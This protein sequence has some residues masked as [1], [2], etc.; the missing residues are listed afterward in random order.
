VLIAAVSAAITLALGTMLATFA[1]T[2]AQAPGSAAT[3]APGAAVAPPVGMALPAALADIPSD[4][5][6]LYQQA[7]QTCPGLS[8]AVLAGIGK[9]ES[10]NGLSALPGVSPGTVNSAGAGGP[11]QF[12][13]PTFASVIAKHVIPPGG[14]NPPSLYNA[15]DA[16]Y[17]AAYYLCDNGAH[18]GTNINGALWTYNHSQAYIN[19]VLAQANRYY[20]AAV[21]AQTPTRAA[22]A[23][24]APQQNQTGA[25]SGSSAT[26]RAV[27]GF[28]QAQIGSNYV[29]GGNGSADGGFDCSG[30][31][32]AAYRA[33]GIT[34]PRTAQTQYNTGPRLP[35]GAT[36]KPG[37]LVFFGTG[38]NHVTHVGIATSPTTMIDAPDFGTTVRQD[39]IGRNL[40]GI[41]RPSQS[42]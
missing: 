17:A 33:A 40:V 20:R 5:L 9:V 6:Q 27:L 16:I 4:Y 3:T 14:Q 28:A 18:N 21:A 12:L 22:P 10:N 23:P 34:L 41:A 1:S 7:A 8:W 26:A 39:P 24:A 2:P 42:Q 35:P 13:A 38:P 29:W 25:G 36:A 15:H 31:T 37:D 11:M 32:T 30:L 19:Q